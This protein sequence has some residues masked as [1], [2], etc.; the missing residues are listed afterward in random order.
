[1]LQRLAKLE[2]GQLAVVDRG[3]ASQ[4]GQA[5]GAVLT[6]AMQVHD[7]RFYRD[8]LLGGG[9]GAAE[10]YIRGYWDSPDLTTAMR[11]LTQ[12]TE[13]L[14][15]VEQ[16]AAR[17]LRPLRTAAN[18][19]RRNTRAGSKRNI[20][21]HYDLSNDFFALMLDPTMTYSSGVFP[22]AESTLEEA[23]VEKYDRI[24]RKLQLSPGD[25]LLEIG[26]GWGGF[27]LHAAQRYGCHVVTTTISDEQHAYA[28]RRFQAAGIEDRVELLR[29]DYRDL[30]GKYDKLVSIEMIEAVGEK[31]LPGY[32]AKCSSLLKPDGMM[33]LQAITI[34]D[35]RY[36]QYRKSVD[37]IQRYIFPGGFLPSMG[38]MATAVGSQTD[39]RFVHTED[40]GP[41]Y[42]KT[43][44]HWR[45][46]FWGAIEAVKALGFDERFV[47]TW[48]YYL[49]YCE[50][51]FREREIGVSQLL[52]T[53][54]ACRREPIL[55]VV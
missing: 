11:V 37:F 28:G 54:P 2:R 21:A 52:L 40:F 27:A 53:K 10:A 4:F 31:Y 23:S 5:D 39:F 19:L 44:A 3:G 46:N 30:S 12:N 7:E 24:C 9:L 35:H 16:G 43:L 32:F 22:T 26:T 25:R 6:A 29:H 34:P 42:A 15:G 14:E 55:T 17:L 49:C 20:A 51:G 8:V 33:C 36:D 41:H 45:A 48:H 38:A 13:F 1:M 50:A 18:W 47:R